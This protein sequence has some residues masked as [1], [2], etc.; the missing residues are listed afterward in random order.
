LE[1]G[2]DKVDALQK[3]LLTIVLW[4]MAICIC[5]IVYVKIKTLI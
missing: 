4:L 3:I 1:R 2:K 5:Y